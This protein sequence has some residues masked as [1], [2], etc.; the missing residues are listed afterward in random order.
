MPTDVWVER[1][2]LDRVGLGQGVVG[3]GRVAAAAR[4]RGRG[5]CG[6]GKGL[7]RK[8]WQNEALCFYKKMQLCDKTELSFYTLL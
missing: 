1:E 6:V 8:Y 5:A 2:N 4:G 3:W 7:C